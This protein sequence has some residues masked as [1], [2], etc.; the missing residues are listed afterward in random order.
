MPSIVKQNRTTVATAGVPV[1]IGPDIP[2]QWIDITAIA[3]NAGIVVIAP[4][5]GIYDAAGDSTRGP[6]ADSATRNG[7]VLDATNGPKHRRF[8]VSNVSDLWIDAAEDGD[9]VDWEAYL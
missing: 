7:Y 8:P 9:G 4:R 1:P 2:C 6:V 3:A 5:A